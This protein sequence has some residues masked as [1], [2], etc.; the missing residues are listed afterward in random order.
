MIQ[1]TYRISHASPEEEQSAVQ[2]VEALLER[3]RESPAYEGAKCVYAKLLM[4]Q[5]PVDKAKEIDGLVREKLPKAVVAGM[6]MSLTIQE[7]N[8]SYILLSFF[9]FE[10]SSVEVFWHGGPPE[11]YGEAGRDFGR[12]IACMRDVKAVEMFAV[13]L[14]IDLA[15]FVLG[16]GEENPEVPFFGS[17]AGMNHAPGPID[18]VES[19]FD[20]EN[21]NV[22]FEEHLPVDCF[23]LGGGIHDA[24]VVMAVFSGEELH[25]R[26]D[27]LLGWK[28]LGKEMAITESPNNNCAA[29]IDGIPAIKI[30]QK[31]LNVLPDARF[32]MNICDFP[33]IMER[34]GLAIARTPPIFDKEGR[35]Y[36]TGDVHRGEKFRLA[37]AN[38]K[39]LI[40]E[41]V[42][43][44]RKMREFQPQALSLIICPNRAIFLRK[45]T[46]LEL[47]PYQEIQPRLIISHGPGEIFRHRGKGGVLNSSLL[48]IGMRE[49]PCPG[50]LP[51]RETNGETASVCEAIPL[52]TRLA[53]FLDATTR[54]L[55][56]SN[57][58]LRVMAEMAK[59]ASVAK[60]RFLSKMSHEIRTPIN[61]ILGMD[62]MILRESRSEDILEYAENIRMAGSNLLGIINDILDFSKIESGKLTILPVEYNMSSLLNDLINMIRK[63]VEDKKLSFAVNSPVDF[64]SYLWGDELRI[65]QVVTNLLTNAV[66]YTKRGFVYLSVDFEKKDEETIFLKVAVQD[67]GIG[68]KEE[69]LKKLFTAFERIEEERNRTIEGTGLGMNITQELLTLMGS[70]LHV[71]SI[72]GKGTSFSFVVEQKVK[73]WT[74]MGDFDEAYRRSFARR[75]AYREEFIAPEARILVVDDTP[76]NLTVVKGLL[77]RTKVQID[78]AECGMD[79]LRMTAERT[80]DIIFL[81]HRMPE[82]DG[83]ETFRRMREMEGNLNGDTPVISL[84]A[85]AVSGAREEYLAEG[86]RDYLPKPIDGHQLELMMLKYLPRDKVRIR[87]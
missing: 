74:P 19:F 68:I 10:K 58:E 72:Y 71:E 64:P 77:K 53:E 33:M 30:Y 14:N 29:A 59:A 12:R 15:P 50:D 46:Y 9:Y 47:V 25:V 11:G 3:L 43:A 54:E 52:S 22:V 44:S 80:Y 51:P 81:D 20:Q 79:C 76:L 87:R 26:A 42:E 56:E 49:G 34:D 70:K 83:I 41:T 63:R 21:I 85:N 18:S 86:F 7:A 39:E 69:D 75:K 61:A 57:A 36:F 6:C 67:S 45:D 23:I 73:D 24:G 8:A 66:K 4:A 32:L 82:M 84:T 78:T 27:Y 65:K 40:R 31:Y 55:K 38:P 62:E 13:V 48:A 37:Y 2:R 5:I 1:E 35:L 17:L 60:S 16:L 28:A